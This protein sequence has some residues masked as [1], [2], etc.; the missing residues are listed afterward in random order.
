MQKEYADWLGSA[1]KDETK[2]RRA[3]QFINALTEKRDKPGR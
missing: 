3:N 2:A 1:K